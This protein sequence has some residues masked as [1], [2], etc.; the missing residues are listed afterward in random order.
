MSIKQATEHI[1]RANLDEINSTDHQRKVADHWL[2]SRSMK[3]TADHF[4]I[5]SSRVRQIV[6]RTARACVYHDSISMPDEFRGLSTRSY[7]AL[8]AV[9]LKDGSE[10]CLT[11]VKEMA[12]WPN[13]GR[14]SIAE[15]LAH[16]DHP[17]HKRRS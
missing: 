12:K 3:E 16:F 15:V 14:K 1:E 6:Y 17:E 8:I 2:K 9:G 7:N 10:V 13:F 5:S 11:P 4:E